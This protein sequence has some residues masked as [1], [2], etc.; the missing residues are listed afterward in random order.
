MMLRYGVLLIKSPSQRVL[1]LQ[2]STLCPHQ[3]LKTCHESQSLGLCGN[4]AEQKASLS[5]SIKNHFWVSEAAD[6]GA[7]SLSASVGH[8]Q[9]AGRQEDLL[10]HRPTGARAFIPKE[11]SLRFIL[12]LKKMQRMQGAKFPWVHKLLSRWAPRPQPCC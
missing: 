6:P 2:A 9:E 8:S 3:D 1:S 7:H 10:A 4:R 11:R 12:A 5:L